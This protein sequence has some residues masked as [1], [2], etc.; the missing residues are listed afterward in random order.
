[1]KLF[2]IEVS[3]LLAILALIMGVVIGVSGCSI[4]SGQKTDTEI[5]TPPTPGV[6]LWNAAKRSNW[7]VTISIL[8]IAVGVFALVN[9]SVKLGTASIASASVSLFMTLAVARFAMWMAVFGLIGSI[10]AALFSIFV[11][12]KALVEI[13]H[14]VQVAKKKSLRPSVPSLINKS[15]AKEQSITTK[16]IVNN[17]KNQLKL[18]GEI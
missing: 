11:R 5:V 7:L 14:G 18:N 13:I 17:I 3:I 8:G 6:Q 16:K 4:F 10:A 2:V 1:M 15:L 9:G 12:R